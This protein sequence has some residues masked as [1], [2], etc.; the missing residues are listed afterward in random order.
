MGIPVLIIL[1]SAVIVFFVLPQLAKF[2]ATIGIDTALKSGAFSLVQKLSLIVL[3]LKTPFLNTLAFVWIFLITEG[4]DLRSY[5]WE[6]IMS[7]EHAVWVITGLWAAGIW[8]HFSGLQA[9]A[10]TPP[11]VTP[12]PSAI[13]VPPAPPAAPK[14]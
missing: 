12:F 4:D 6:Q 1:I 11:V 2:R 9:A 3:G 7:H 8:S 5:A 13:P 14:V 10:A